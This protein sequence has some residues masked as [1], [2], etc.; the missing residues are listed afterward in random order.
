MA[1]WVYVGGQ[2]KSEHVSDA[3]GDQRGGTDMPDS[4]VAFGIKFIVNQPVEVS[5]DRFATDAQ[6][7][8][9][10]AKLSTNQFFKPV[11]EDVE[12]EPAV[13]PVKRGPGRPKSEKVDAAL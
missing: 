2:T 4:T 8:H 11:A 12:P 1:K 7:R 3:E 9:A 13:E 5:R 10:L 6:H